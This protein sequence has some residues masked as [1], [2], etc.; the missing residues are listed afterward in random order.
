MDF[1]EKMKHWNGRR[2]NDDDDDD[3]SDSNSSES[4]IEIQ[5]YKD[6]KSK[7]KRKN[8]FRVPPPP[9]GPFAHGALPPRRSTPPPNIRPRDS[10][11]EPRK[12]SGGG[13]RTTERKYRER[14]GAHGSDSSELSW[15]M[16]DDYSRSSK[17]S[18]DSRRTSLDSSSPPPPRYSHRHAPE[19]RESR[20]HRRNRSRSRD[21]NRDRRDRSGSRSNSDES[22]RRARY[23]ISRRDSVREHRYPAAYEGL[24]PPLEREREAQKPIH[25]HI[26]N[27]ASDAGMAMAKALPAS[28]YREPSPVPSTISGLS[29]L[30]NK[31]YPNPV[32]P[33][34]L[35]YPDTDLPYVPAPPRAPAAPRYVS[36]EEN[37]EAY[38]RSQRR[39]SYAERPH[40]YDA[41]GRMQQRR[42][43]YAEQPRDY[44]AFGRSPSELE[45]ALRQS[46]GDLEQLKRRERERAFPVA[47]SNPILRHRPVDYS[48]GRNEAGV[49]FAGDGY[50]PREK[51]RFSRTTTYV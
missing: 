20:R 9:M 23:H 31:R 33:R 38:M 25:V 1:E 2:G 30:E 8:D 41:F 22:E 4:I 29:F 15:D 39:S 16:V 13:K 46:R 19:R 34:R 36:P 10:E 51:L 47:G 6:N 50:D 7:N 42:A 11:R 49:R 27:N 17:S 5:D 28:Q 21:Y 12:K 32:V 40:N 24:S 18:Y 43:S 44:D 26:H 48:Q 14:Y 45:A 35:P 3:D 37:A